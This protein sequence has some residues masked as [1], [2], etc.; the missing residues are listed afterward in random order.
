MCCPGRVRPSQEEVSRLPYAASWDRSRSAIGI[1]SVPVISPTPLKQLEVEV[2]GGR[3]RGGDADG[4]LAIVCILDGDG[5]AGVGGGSW[6]AVLASSAWTR[7]QQFGVTL[8]F[9]KHEGK[10]EHDRAAIDGVRD[11]TRSCWSLASGHPGGFRDGH[12]YGAF[13]G[14]FMWHVSTACMSWHWLTFQNDTLP[15]PQSPH[16]MVTYSRDLNTTENVVR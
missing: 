13:L 7:N 6:M 1:P 16:G 15:G 3:A 8:R 10:I 5:G 4:V 9:N 11:V 2:G 12:L 14:H